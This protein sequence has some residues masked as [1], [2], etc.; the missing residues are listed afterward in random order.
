MGPDLTVR[1]LAHGAGVKA[2]L[3]QQ[4][5][6]LVLLVLCGSDSVNIYEH[7]ASTHVCS[8]DPLVALLGQ[9]DGQ[10]VRNKAVG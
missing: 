9:H 4:S 7:R 1:A 6:P 3:P 8:Y 5:G 2:G 10:S